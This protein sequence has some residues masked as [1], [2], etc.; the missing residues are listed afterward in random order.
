MVIVLVH[1]TGF[2][3]TLVLEIC[4]FS[5]EQHQSQ[6]FRGFKQAQNHTKEKGD[7]REESGEE[8]RLLALKIFNI[9][10]FGQKS[11]LQKGACS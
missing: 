1:L 11:E 2:W 7:G 9:A 10:Y 4:L 6:G 3:K 8:K 5:L